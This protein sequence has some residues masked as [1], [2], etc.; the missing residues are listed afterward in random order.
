M[1]SRGIKNFLMLRLE[2]E[3]SKR[4]EER[5]RHDRVGDDVHGPFSNKIL[6]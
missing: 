6:S 2:V 4:S 1:K 3:D 5:Q